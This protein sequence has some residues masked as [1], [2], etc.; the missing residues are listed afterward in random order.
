[1][2][3]WIMIGIGLILAVGTGLFVASEFALVNLD[4]NDVE[5]RQARGEKR[6]MPTIKAPKITSTHL[7]SAQLGITLTTLLTP[8]LDDRA[9]FRAFDLMVGPLRVPESMGVDSLLGVLRRQ[10][11]QVAV[12]ACS[13]SRWARAALILAPPVVVVARIFN[14]VIWTLSSIANGVL[15]AGGPWSPRRSRRRWGPAERAAAPGFGVAPASPPW[16]HRAGPSLPA[17]VPG[18]PRGGGGLGP[19]CG[20]LRT[21]LWSSQVV[22]LRKVAA[23]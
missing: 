17:S 1:M 3:E 22:A 4:R 9:R 5:A 18:Q 16:I 12:V 14:P 20:E 7:S 11:L 8:P 2:N 15:R 19:G 6:L 21:G 13:R 10:G 23:Q